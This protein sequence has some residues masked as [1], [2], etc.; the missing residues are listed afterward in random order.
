MYSYIC[1]GLHTIDTHFCETFFY[2]PNSCIMFY[3]ILLSMTQ[4]HATYW[5]NW[6]S[7]VW[8]VWVS[9][10]RTFYMSQAHVCYQVGKGHWKHLRLMEEVLYQKFLSQNSFYALPDYGPEFLPKPFFP[11]KMVGYHWPT[12]AASSHSGKP[13]NGLKQL[14]KGSQ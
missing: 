14:K 2:K 10:F 7:V 3:F 12:S 9:F 6:R 5:G 4:A 13:P 8:R 11:L 1:T